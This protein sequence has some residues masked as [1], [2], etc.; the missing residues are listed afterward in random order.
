MLVAGKVQHVQYK[1]MCTDTTK[2]AY[3]CPKQ[4]VKG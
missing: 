4:A 1:C 3:Y 2:F